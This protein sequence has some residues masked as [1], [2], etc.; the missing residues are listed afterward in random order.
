MIQSED[1]YGC[2]GRNLRNKNLVLVL[3][4]VDKSKAPEIHFVCNKPFYAV[5]SHTLTLKRK[6]FVNLCS[7]QTL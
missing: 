6:L 1:D 3:V 2:A 4:D 5:T 7:Q